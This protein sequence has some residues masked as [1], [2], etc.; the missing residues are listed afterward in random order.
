MRIAFIGQKGIPS[1]VSSRAGGVER[2]VEGL[3]QR[4]AER[5]HTVSV[6]CRPY[7]NPQR[8]KMW[9]RV[10][11]ITLPTIER[12]NFDTIFHSFLATI[13]VLFQPVD[14]I[15]YHS[16]GPSTLAWIPRIFKP[17]AKVV[18]TFHARDRFHEKWRWPARAFLAFGEWAICHFPHVT[19]T[20]SHGLQ[21]YCQKM[22]GRDAI[23]IPNAVSLPVGRIGAS[24]IHDLG[25][26][27]NGYFIMLGRLIPVK[28]FDDAIRAFRKIETKKK[29]LIVGDVSFDSLPYKVQL[30]TLADDDERIILMGFRKGQELQELLANCYAMIHPARSE[31]LS[32]AVLEAMSYGKLVIMS[33]IPGNRELVDHSGVA[34]PVGNLSALQDAIEWVISDP[35]LTHIRGRRAKK[36]IKELYSWDR[37]I[38]RTESVY[39]SPIL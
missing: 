38:E 2:H 31:G 29:L 26:E 27:T 15:H 22:H 19:I 33:N 25:L 6:Y 36:V 32:M 12:K 4:L 23:H 21:L 3:S 20:V 9:K 16:V 18:A 34:Y 1:S 13:H 37:L 8:K 30:E 39:Q 24:K 5:G 11:L 35:V 10:H 28:A 17:G 7:M 14:V